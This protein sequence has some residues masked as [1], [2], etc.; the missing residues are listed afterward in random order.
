MIVI[1]RIRP[2]LIACFVI[3]GGAS[4]KKAATPPT[5][6]LKSNSVHHILILGNSITYAPADPSIGWNGSWGMAATTADKDYV[7]LLT[8]RFKASNN[9]STL[10][11]VNI[12]AFEV[13][14]DNY[15]LDANLKTYRDAKPDAIIIRI[16]ENVTRNNDADLFEQ[17]Y[18]DLLGYLRTGNP[19]VKILAVGS[20]WPDRDLANRVMGKYSDYITLISLQQSS[21]NFAYGLYDNYGVQTHPSDKGMQSISDM[22]WAKIVTML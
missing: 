11:A 17:K 1:S 22:I 14:F 12:A 8:A 20:V 21:P 9:N 5:P 7:H 18:V 15:D 2:L 10:V 6:T 3:V 19:D 13:G 4:C 16:G